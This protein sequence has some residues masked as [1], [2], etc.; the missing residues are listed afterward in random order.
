M[1]VVAV[2]VAVPIL[3][4]VVVNALEPGGVVVLVVVSVVGGGVVVVIVVGGWVGGWGRLGLVVCVALMLWR[5]CGLVVDIVVA[6]RLGRWWGRW[7]VVVPI[8]YHCH[9]RGP[10]IAD[11]AALPPVVM[12]LCWCMGHQLPRSVLRPPLSCSGSMSDGGP[13]CLV[14]VCPFPTMELPSCSCF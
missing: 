6:G 3:E 2:V 11:F 12:M 1:V 5:W 10:C 14:G 8:L 4:V 9:F 7:G 13:R